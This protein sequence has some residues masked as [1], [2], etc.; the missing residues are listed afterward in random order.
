[1]SSAPMIQQ[2]KGPAPRSYAGVPTPQQP[3]GPIPMPPSIPATDDAN[4]NMHIALLYNEI[5]H[6]R[7]EMAKMSELIGKMRDTM[8]W[9]KTRVIVLCTVSGIGGAGIGQLI[10]AVAK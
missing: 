8:D 2:L 5:H 4:Q 7:A 1:M 10:E 6:L 9:L 3:M